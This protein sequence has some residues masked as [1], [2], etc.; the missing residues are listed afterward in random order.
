MALKKSVNLSGLDI[1]EG[2]HKIGAEA[3]LNR[4]DIRRNRLCSRKWNH[5]QANHNLWCR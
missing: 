2:Y 5:C 3:S 4:M 1:P